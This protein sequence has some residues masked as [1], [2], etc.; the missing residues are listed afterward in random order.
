MAGALASRAKASE[1][2]TFTAEPSGRLPS[3]S[4]RMASDTPIPAE[5]KR[6][7]SAIE[8]AEQRREA[9]GAEFFRL[10]HGE[11][12]DKEAGKLDQLIVGAPRMPVARAD[13]E[14]EPPVELGCR[15]EIAHR[16]DDVVEPAGH[17]KPPS[18]HR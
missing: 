5:R 12:F 2:A 1:K 13:G 10:R 6:A 17:R 4:K 3:R 9:V 16:M 18:L 14:A 11:Q 15:L 8:G 7:A